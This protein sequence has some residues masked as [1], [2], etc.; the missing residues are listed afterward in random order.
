VQPA[1]PT[2]ELLAAIPGITAHLASILG[3]LAALIARAFLK[4]PVHVVHIVPLWNYIGR[5]ARRFTRTMDRLAEGKLRAHTP[6]PNRTPATAAQP[7]KPR[8]YPTTHAWLRATLAHEANAYGSQLAH[9]LD[10]PETKALLAAAPQ[11]ARLLRPLCRYLG[12]EPDAI[13]RPP[14]PPAPKA[15]HPAKPEPP[16]LARLRAEPPAEPSVFSPRPIQPLCPRL[17]D[18]WPWNAL[19]A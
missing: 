16:R 4:H 6:R 19:T 8:G 13:R 3:N 18:R 1:L 14:R 10:Q 12:I 15:P 2:A 17:L 11:A 9:L 7:R 5:I